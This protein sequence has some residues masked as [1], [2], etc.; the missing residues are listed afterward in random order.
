MIY[1][2]DIV[3]PIPFS[4]SVRWIREGARMLWLS[5]SNANSSVRGRK[6]RHWHRPRPFDPIP[7]WV[8]G[9]SSRAVQSMIDRFWSFSCLSSLDFVWACDKLC[10]FCDDMWGHM[11]HIVN[12][13]SG[14]RIVEAR[15]VAV[16][17][18]DL[19]GVSSRD[20]L[21]NVLSR[22]VGV[23]RCIWR[24]V[25]RIGAHFL[26]RSDILGQF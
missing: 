3:V 14:T 4:V 1:P 2:L 22:R 15:K 26:F 11:K 12:E 23:K 8:Y 6:L 25:A 13:C 10:P 18:L 5:W 21:F 24:A 19:L 20:H 17:E 7:S 16:A 9:S